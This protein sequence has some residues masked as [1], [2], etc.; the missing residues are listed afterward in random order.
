MSGDARRT[1]ASHACGSTPFILAVTM[2]LYMA[3]ARGPPRSDPQNN[4]VFRPSAAQRSPR[5]A[6][7]LDMQTR[8]S[9][10]NRVKAGQRLSIYWGAFTRS[11]PRDIRADYADVLP[12]AF[13]CFEDN[14]GARIAHLRLPVTHRRFAR[15][16]NCSNGYSSRSSEGSKSSPTVSAKSRCSN[17]RSAARRRP[18]SFCGAR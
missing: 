14:F 3:A 16:T 10:R 8:P 9:S 1:S 11:C 7:L 4:Q 2:R 15:T 6:A 12:S 18:T 17:S 5:S 13:A